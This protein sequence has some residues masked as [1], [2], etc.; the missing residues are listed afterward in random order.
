[1]IT[2]ELQ[3][4]YLQSLSNLIYG[5]H[6][7]NKGSSI[8]LT[9]WTDS[10]TRNIRKGQNISS[11]DSFKTENLRQLFETQSTC[12]GDQYTRLKLCQW[13]ERHQ[14]NVKQLELNRIGTVAFTVTS[15]VLLI[16]ILGYACSKL[17]SSFDK[18]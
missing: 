5:V 10:N 4:I 13:W 14:S 17:N 3:Y 9:D 8:S 6:R 11:N 18:F 2:T 1:V 12:S 16:G 15:V 7:Y